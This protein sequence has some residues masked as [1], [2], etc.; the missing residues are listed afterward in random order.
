M[1][2]QA[3]KNQIPPKESELHRIEPNRLFELTATVFFILQ[4][5][6][7]FI[8]Y[9]W[10]VHEGFYMFSFALITVALICLYIILTTDQR[11]E[12]ILH[13]VLTGIVITLLGI[14]SYVQA[15][16]NISLLTLDFLLILL[17]GLHSNA[18]SNKWYFIYNLLGV[19]SLTY[20]YIFEVEQFGGLYSTFALTEIIFA[21]GTAFVLLLVH[22]I[23][24][25]H[26]KYYSWEDNPLKNKI[27]I[28]LDVFTIIHSENKNLE[29]TLD[30]VISELIPYLDLEECNIFLMNP[31]QKTLRKATFFSRKS[32]SEETICPNQIDLGKGI[33]GHVA[34]SGIPELIP[35]VRL[36]IRYIKGS[37]P[38]KNEICV[39][40]LYEGQVLGVLDS[41]HSQVGFF[42]QTHLYI[43]DLI[44]NLLAS[45]IM[46]IEHQ[47]KI[48]LQNQ[49]EIESKHLQE[50][51]RIKTEFISN[52]SHDLKTPLTLILGPA[53]TLD[54]HPDTAISNIGKVIY[55]NVKG[56]QKIL[57]QLLEL[58]QSG[59]I[60]DD[61][62]L[63][64]YDFAELLKKW[65]IKY[66]NWAKT[67]DIKLQV[68]GPTN[69][70]LTFDEGKMFS[71]ISN[72][73]DNALK[74]TPKGGHIS[75]S[76][77][78]KEDFFWLSV[79][80]SGVGIS[81]E[82]K[83]K[84]FERFYRIGHADATGTGKGLSIVKTYV[85]QMDG[86]IAVHD[87]ELGGCQFTIR[88][89]TS[90]LKGQVPQY[91]PK[92]KYDAPPIKSEIPLVMVVEDHDDL[93]DFLVQVLRK[94]YEVI[95]AWNGKEALEIAKKNAPDL[96]ITDLMMPIMSGEEFTQ[97]IKQIDYLSHIPILVLSAKSRT[98]DK[99][100]LYKIGA[101]NYLQKPFDMEELQVIVDNLLKQRKRLRESFKAQVFESQES[102]FDANEFFEDHFMQELVEILEE[103]LNNPKLSIVDLC[104]AMR[105]GRNQLQKKVKALTNMT[106]V[107]FVR[108]YRIKKALQLLKTTRYSVSEV[109][110]QVGFNNLSYFT[111]M[112][113]KQF[114]VLPSRISEDSEI[115]LKH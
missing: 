86:E 44:A 35:D 98:L 112:F 80:D 114:G 37:Y 43:F 95:P 73:L 92:A 5:L 42:N 38:G 10:N 36:D 15:S 16:P 71:I 17:L 4:A 87:S 70:C 78:L 115:I 90:Y 9:R 109:A 47:E 19:F 93:R 101:D 62:H 91:Y 49:L 79:D 77:D 3:R 96:I 102:S 60:G 97:Q 105:V 83:T 26:L 56:L 85:E 113:K 28:I 29:D 61:M 108:S 55:K 106:P 89:N 39:P 74:Y 32:P 7:L 99:I 31:D 68:D 94:N 41:E 111:K 51:D 107:E 103:Q 76:Y 40:I 45:R 8:N 75:I 69:L 12:L 52:I 11:K 22:R 6:V 88:L 48:K 66:Q 58:N 100:E 64:E 25:K 1:I 27:G 18:I 23:I 20:P 82:E 34:Q 72:L 46:Y 63:E 2:I 50:L 14:Q 81:E 13:V 65:I 21:V 54:Q 104:Q 67:E 84:I 57:E 110:Y 24:Q 59:F 33:I 30:Q 53:K